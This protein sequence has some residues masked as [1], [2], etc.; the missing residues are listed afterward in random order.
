MWYNAENNA[1]G[2][3]KQ[4]KKNKAENIQA[5]LS[6][7]LVLSS[8]VCGIMQKTMQLAEKNRTRRTRRK[9]SRCS[10]G[11]LFLAQWYVV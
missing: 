6:G 7:R 11:V 1:I 3:E 5:V 2:G 10:A 4:N 9:I 8:V